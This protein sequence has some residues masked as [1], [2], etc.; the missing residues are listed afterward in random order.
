MT[1]HNRAHGASPS[2]SLAPPG[3]AGFVF[4]Q[5]GGFAS[6]PSASA[7]GSKVVVFFTDFG[8]VILN[9]TKLYPAAG[10]YSEYAAMDAAAVLTAAFSSPSTSASSMFHVLCF[11]WI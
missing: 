11:Q 9:G 5:V 3:S 1:I 6:I 10:P 4:A 8:R 7:P 2:L